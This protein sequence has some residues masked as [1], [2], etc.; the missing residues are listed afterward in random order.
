MITFWAAL[1]I[2]LNASFCMLF[3]SRVMVMITVRIRFSVGFVSGY[4]HIIYTAFVAIVTLP[5]N[6]ARH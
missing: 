6:V 3:S 5:N 4:A 2:W 1:Y